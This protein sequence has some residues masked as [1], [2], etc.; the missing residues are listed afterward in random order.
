MK[1]R[2]LNP[3][4]GA[5][6]CSLVIFRFSVDL[7]QSREPCPSLRNSRTSQTSART[8]SRDL[9]QVLQLESSVCTIE[10]DLPQSNSE[11]PKTATGKCSAQA[12]VS[13][14][15]WDWLDSRKNS[16]DISSLEFKVLLSGKSS[17]LVVF[18]PN[19]IKIR[20][21][22]PAHLQVT[23]VQPRSQPEPVTVTWGKC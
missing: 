16:W 21:E 20:T 17:Q 9:E 14:S 3:V 19:W 10:R 15:Q 18:H 2:I 4:R 13:Q 1:D 23:E 22:S 11:C 8:S 7:D 6:V 12:F 5:L